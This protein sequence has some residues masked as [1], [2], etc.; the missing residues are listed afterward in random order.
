MLRRLL[1]LILCIAYL[2]LQAQTWL[3]LGVQGG[4]GLST[5]LNKNIIDDSKYPYSFNTGYHVGGK[6]SLNF[7]YYNGIFLEAGIGNYEE[8]W[9]YFLTVNDVNVDYTHKIKWSTT[10]LALLY[11]V[12]NLG[13]YLEVGPQLSLISEVE[14][15]DNGP[16]ALTTIN[17]K[18]TSFYED[19]YISGVLGFGGFIAGNEFVSLDFGLR[20]SYAFT[21]MVNDQ[22]QAINYPNPNRDAASDYSDYKRSAP[23][24]VQAR[25][26]LT[27]GVGGFAKSGCGQRNFFIG[28]GRR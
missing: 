25:L 14:Q 18:T 20:A 1:P 28:G 26:G 24:F 22:G 27:F 21:D 8:Q 12:T 4:Y 7:G 23:L 19:Q 5:I 10:D 16:I 11:R 13:V 17:G 9:D 2:P 3:E 15:E 6:L